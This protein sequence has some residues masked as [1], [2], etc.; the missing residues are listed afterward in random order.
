[1]VDETLKFVEDYLDSEDNNT[2][3]PGT[4]K[5]HKVIMHAIR[6]SSLEGKKERGVLEKKITDLSDLFLGKNPDRSNGVMEQIKT[7][8]RFRKT[9]TWI[10]II[11]T[12]AFLGGL[13]K[14]VWGLVEL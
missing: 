6:H 1:M 7:N 9:V 4:P 13:G 11:I 2:L 8:T 3:P 5:S 12:T 10:L 14:W